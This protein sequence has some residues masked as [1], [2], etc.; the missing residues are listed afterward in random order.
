MYQLF[1]IQIII[2]KYLR[3]L[4]LS[5][6][7]LQ[8]VTQCLSDDLQVVDDAEFNKLI[9]DE[10]YVVALFCTSTNTERCEEFEGELAGIRED[11]IDVMDGDGW[12]V[13][14]VNSE[15][16]DRFYV[17]KTD[18]PLI[19]M[20]RNNLPVIYNGELKLS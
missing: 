10:K 2:M 8:L 20:F 13:K 14:L 9:V 4:V 7:L 18:Q 12:V 19:I 17:G 11:L 1:Q 5:F 6:Y 16:M 3:T 15:V